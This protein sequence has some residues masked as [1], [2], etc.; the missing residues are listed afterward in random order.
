MLF[1]GFNV[2]SFRLTFTEAVGSVTLEA[3]S[4][5]GLDPTI[6]TL[7]AFDASDN[8]WPPT[9]RVDPF[10]STNTLTVTSADGDNIKYFTIATDDPDNGGLGFSNIV[11]ACH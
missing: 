1:S 7:T 8:S 5:N 10:N 11:W 4:A 2:N 6:E 9:A 3:Q